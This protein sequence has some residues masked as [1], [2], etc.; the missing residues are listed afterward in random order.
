MLRQKINIILFATV[1]VAFLTTNLF[2]TNGYFR[3]GYGIKYSAL[4]GSGVAVSLSSLGAISNPAGIVFIGNDRYDINISY[5]SPSREYT[6][7]GNP[8]PPPAFGLAP[9]TIESD[10]S[11]FFFPTLGANWNLNPTMAIGV[12]VYGNG[13]MNT[14]YPTATFHDPSSGV[15]GVNLEQLFVGATYAIEVTKGHSLAVQGLFGYQKFS[16]TGLA[17]FAP[18]SS[19]P[20]NLTGNANSTATGFGFKVGYQGMIGKMIRIGGAYQSKINMSEFDRYAGL[21]AEKGDFDVPAN[22]QAGIAVIPADALTLLFDVQQILYSGVKSV[23]NPMDA[24]ALP[25]AFPDGMGGFVPNPNHVPLGADNGSGFGWEDMTIYKFGI[26]YILPDAWT[27]YGG[28]SYGKQPIPSTEVLFNILAPATVETHIT[29]GFSKYINKSNEI[30]VSFMYAPE[31]GVSG[32]N[33]FDP[34]QTIEIRMSQFQ[35]EIGYAFSVVQ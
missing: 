13:G 11:S 29:L 20:A 32:T 18:F 8:S 16:A 7:T 24:M 5:F 33:Q 9:G 19:D 35:L 34:A 26:M 14:D 1:M 6:V 10:N 4:A 31:K 12:V 30:M 3:H 23:A 15:T 28:F 25:P 27:L 17:S 22:W 2:A 21:F